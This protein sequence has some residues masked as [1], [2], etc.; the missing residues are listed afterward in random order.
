MPLSHTLSP[1]I[2]V[3]TLPK[4][5]HYK[6]IQKNKVAEPSKVHEPMSS[7]SLGAHFSFGYGWSLAVIADAHI[8]A[9]LVFS[10]Q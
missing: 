4:A 1:Y 10:S 2:A 5:G 9:S 6:R 8:N 3:H 7:S